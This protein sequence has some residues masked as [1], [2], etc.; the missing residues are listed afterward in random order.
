MNPNYYQAKYGLLSDGTSVWSKKADSYTK[1]INLDNLVTD[2]VYST[3][4]STT[5]IY[6]SKDWVNFS[7]QTDLKIENFSDLLNLVDVYLDCFKQL[8]EKNLSLKSSLTDQDIKKY[9]SII[10]INSDIFTFIAI[11]VTIENN[12]E[13][14]T[15]FAE[16]ENQFGSL[17][18][19][20]NFSLFDYQKFVK[21]WYFNS[22]T[23]INS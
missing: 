8:F 9:F 2:K 5:Y 12:K 4:D 14:V 23:S 6:F 15:K 3:L 10:N 19:K 1:E 16:Y 7:Y 13:L 11:E 22:D 18:N 21:N 20:Y 17:C